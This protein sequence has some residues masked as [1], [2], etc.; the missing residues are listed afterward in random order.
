MPWPLLENVAAGLAAIGL[1]FLM[2][3]VLDRRR[4]RRLNAEAAARIQRVVDGL[5][6]RS[7][8]P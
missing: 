8:R 3:E 6:L 7:R 2:I 4:S 5:A 1:C